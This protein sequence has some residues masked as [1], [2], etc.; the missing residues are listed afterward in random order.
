VHNRVVEGVFKVFAFLIMIS[1]AAPGARR[2]RTSGWDICPF[3][4]RNG[5]P[6]EPP[7][8][9]IVWPAAS[10]GTT[11]RRCGRPPLCIRRGLWRKGR[12]SRRRTTGRLWS[13]P[14][15]LIH[16]RRHRY[17]RGAAAGRPSTSTSVAEPP[18]NSTAAVYGVAVE[19][20][21]GAPRRPRCA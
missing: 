14:G 6:M 20:R 13:L 17:Y 21:C 11:D 5:P 19:G 2:P 1:G 7:L 18:E 8:Y 4:A 15:P 9:V 12:P 16:K 3:I 10:T